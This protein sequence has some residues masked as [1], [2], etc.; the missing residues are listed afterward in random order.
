MAQHSIVHQDLRR[1]SRTDFTALRAWVQRVPIGRV[2]DLY[3]SDDAPQVIQG[4]EQFLTGMRLDLIER[5]I[6]ANPRLADML[7]KARLGGPISAGVLDLLVKAADAKPSPATPGDHIGQWLRSKVATQ[8]SK[9]GIRTVGAL[10]AFIETNGPSWWRPIPRI[11]ALRARAILAW[12]NK[13]PNC[14]VNPAT[15]LVIADPQNV[16]RLGSTPLPLQRIAQL[17]AGLD[18]STGLNRASRFCF[19]AARNDL[20]AVRRHIQKFRQQEHTARVYVPKP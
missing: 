11:G 17:P 5:S 18:G 6:L 12:L 2:R 19:V 16:S 15:Q 1:Y 13:T 3:Y 14:A 8:L 7:A 20:K 9:E 10:K 4:L